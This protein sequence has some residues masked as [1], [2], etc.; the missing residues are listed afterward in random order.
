M[1]VYFDSVVHYTSYFNNVRQIKQIQIHP[2]PRPTPESLEDC[3]WVL[4]NSVGL[5]ICSIIDITTRW[6]L[7]LRNAMLSVFCK[8]QNLAY[9]TPT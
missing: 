5:K 7:L 9:Q 6:Y 8:E 4:S 3:G 1:Y 2:E